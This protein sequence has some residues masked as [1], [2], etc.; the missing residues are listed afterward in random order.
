MIAPAAATIADQE[1]REMQWEKRGLPMKRKKKKRKLR[2]TVIEDERVESKVVETM[3]RN[4]RLSDDRT[5]LENEEKY[6]E[7]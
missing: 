4:Q 7:I 5:E 2:R 6:D 1:P 3:Q